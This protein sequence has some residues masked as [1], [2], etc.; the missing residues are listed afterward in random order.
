MR[1]LA[2]IAAFVS[3]AA[4]AEDKSVLLASADV[5]VTASDWY[6]RAVLAQPV[7]PNRPRFYSGTASNTWTVGNLVTTG[8]AS[9]VSGLTASS[10]PVHIGGF[11]ASSAAIWLTT[12][13]STTNYALAQLESSA[14]VLNSRSGQGISLQVAGS[15]K[16]T[17]DVNGGLSSA[18]ISGSNAF[19]ASVE[20]ARFAFG[21]DTS[22]R[23]EGT[24]VRL[25]AGIDGTAGS[26]TG[27]TTNQTS[28]IAH[29]VHKITIT[30]TALTAAGT[31]DITIW[32]TPAN[33]RIIRLLAEV[34]QV[35]TGGALT[36]VTVQCGNAAG[37]TQYLLANSVFTAQNT[38]GDA[39]GEIGNGLLSATV[40]DMGTSSA[41]IPG[42]ITI[43]CRFTCTT[44]NCNAAT[45]G[46]VT[47][48]I[49]HLVYP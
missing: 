31:T 34:T 14:T 40:A 23:E 15:T 37:G 41:G 35:F 13:P 46:S 47:F 45:Q 24:R 5:G 26:G 11:S 39:A 30:N 4:L 8:L 48:E 42:A 19:A 29:Q 49:E 43:S 27:I 28:A 20:G 33:A 9:G 44:A 38:W 10:I 17:M 32:T 36:A 6:T 7:D 21:P 2:F 1:R 18:Q 25:S 12:S 16:V 22:A 3:V